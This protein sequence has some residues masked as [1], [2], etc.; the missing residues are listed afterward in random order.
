HDQSRLRAGPGGGTG[1]ARLTGGDPGQLLF[2]HSPTTSS[3]NQRTVSRYSSRLG[4]GTEVQIQLTPC[5]ASCATSSRKRR[6]LALLASFGRKGGATARSKGPV[7]SSSA[8]RAR[9]R[10]SFSPK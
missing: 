4:A 5:S 6:A 10:P 3:P 1:R 7:R 9:K 2:S 8:R